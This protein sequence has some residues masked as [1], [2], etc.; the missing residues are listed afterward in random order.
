[1]NKP[2]DADA[3]NFEEQ[4]MEDEPMLSEGNDGAYAEDEKDE[5]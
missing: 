3:W 2:Y 4:C 1:M 5:E